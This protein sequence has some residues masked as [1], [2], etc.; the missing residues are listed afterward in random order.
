VLDPL[1]RWRYPEYWKRR[2][3]GGLCTSLDLSHQIITVVAFR[4]IT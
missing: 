3:A 2:L 1:A 4:P